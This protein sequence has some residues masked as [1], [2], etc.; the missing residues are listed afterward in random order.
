MKRTKVFAWLTVVL[1]LVAGAAA[2]L[3]PA[4]SEESAAFHSSLLLSV[5]TTVAQLG[6]ASLFVWGLRG[7]KHQ[8][9]VAYGIICVGIVVL[10]F[11]NL[12]LPIVTY[13]DLTESIYVKGGIISIPY[14][15]PALLVFFGVR[16]FARLFQIK[17]LWMSF[18]FVMGIAVVSAACAAGLGSVVSP[19]SGQELLASIGLSA[20]TAVFLL[21]SVLIVLAIGRVAGP[22]YHDALRWFAA[23][24]IVVTLTSLSYT[25]VLIFL[26]DQSPISKYGG[27][28]V[29][30]AIA[31][32]LFLVSG[33]AFKLINEDR[34][35]QGLSKAPNMID[36]VTFAASQASN[37]SEVDATLDTLRK[38]TS[39][40]STDER[41]LTTEQQEML[42]HVYADIEQYLVAKEPLRRLTAEEVRRKGAQYFGM[43]YDA[44]VAMVRP[45]A[46][47]AVPQAPSASAGQ[48]HI[49]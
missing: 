42:K 18:W 14:I 20:W 8:L 38:M 21:A 29:P 30:S 2:L 49:E 3:V 37:P 16:L 10:A 43:D 25:F 22:L 47:R 32:F 4:P 1:A 15:A 33:Y 31:A 27:V 26:G 48:A 46:P 40:M 41:T 12:Q 11:S 13:F 5:V 6:A 28:L 39:R 17:T 35:T 45:N 44:F 19:A 7:F 23:A 34:V 9:R 36:V 24:R